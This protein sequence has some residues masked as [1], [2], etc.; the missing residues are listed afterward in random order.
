MKGEGQIK[1]RRL[2]GPAP[3][4]QLKNQFSDAGLQTCLRKD[5]RC[6]CLMFVLW[7]VL[8]LTRISTG[9]WSG[10]QLALSVYTS[11]LGL[12]ASALWRQVLT[13]SDPGG[14]YSLTG[15]SACTAKGKDIRR[16][17]N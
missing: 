17:V 11:S 6:F 3:F 9:I 7:N 15:S 5:A 10:L 8:G 2:K 4:P 12:R 13:P 14:K 16:V 1:Q